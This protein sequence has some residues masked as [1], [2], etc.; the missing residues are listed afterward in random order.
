MG[1]RKSS[2]SNALGCLV[3]FVI[4]WFVI[5]IVTQ[6][7]LGKDAAAVGFWS[8]VG[9]GVLYWLAGRVG[10]S[11]KPVSPGMVVAG[12]EPIPA[13][14]RFD[15]L[16]RDGFRCHYCGKGKAEGALL[17]IDHLVPVARGGRT[18]LDNLVTACQR[19]NVGKG[20]RNLVGDD[21]AHGPT[22]VAQKGQQ[23]GIKPSPGVSVRVEFHGCPQCGAPRGQGH[24]FCGVCGLDYTVAEGAAAVTEEGPS[25][26]LA[27][28]VEDD[29]TPQAAELVTSTGRASTSML[30]TKLEIGFNRA[31]RIMD[32]LERCGIVGPQDPRNPAVPREVYGPDNWTGSLDQDNAMGAG[33]PVERG[34]S[35]A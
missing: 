29:M 22:L 23:M 16:S 24:R 25:P 5:V 15:V 14:L 17:Q 3:M 28:Y 32:D 1:K 7:S 6:Q 33:P 4:G 34:P 26:R 13:K 19:C 8:M 30:Q 20:A 21:I 35:T 27:D 12:R 9:L 31:T 2:G 18:T 11:G 10:S